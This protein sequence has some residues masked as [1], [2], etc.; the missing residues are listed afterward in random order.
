MLGDVKR[1]H[2]R[3]DIDENDLPM[4]R[5][6]A[7]RS[8][9]SRDGPGVRFP[10]EFV[11]VEPYVIPKTE[12][13]RREHRA[14]RHA[15]A[16]GVYA[17]PDEPPV[18][19][20][21]GQQMD[22]Y[23]KAAARPKGITLDTSKGRPFE[24][25]RIADPL[26][27]QGGEPASR[28]NPPSAYQGGAGRSRPSAS[29]SFLAQRGSD[30]PERERLRGGRVFADLVVQDDIEVVVAGL[31]PFHRDRVPHED[32]GGATLLLRLVID[33][34]RLSLDDRLL[35]SATDLAVLDQV[36]QIER[37][38]PPDPVSIRL[39]IDRSFSS[40]VKVAP[41]SGSKFPNPSIEAQATAA[42]IPSV[43]DS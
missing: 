39:M 5:P 21:V 33:Q 34:L 3:V 12:P 19:V 42:L 13:H 25:R 8:P 28:S 36:D 22:V 41:G 4:F 6:R 17:L 30:D 18:H 26:G 43:F 37:P 23:M 35:T 7:R 27:G 11:Y 16:P 1:L 24:G 38:H 15:G 40:L 31:Q 29:P 32:R 20:Y 2:V 9:P 10:L 14:G